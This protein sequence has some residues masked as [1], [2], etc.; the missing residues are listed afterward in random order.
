[1]DKYIAYILLV[2]ISLFVLK[3]LFKTTNVPQI[4]NNDD[5]NEHYK[6]IYDSWFSTSAKCYKVDDVCISTFP[7]MDIPEHY[8][9]IRS[10]DNYKVVPRHGGLMKILRNKGFETKEC[11]ETAPFFERS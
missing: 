7:N 10:K 3:L 8:K 2:V 9:I 6:C 1:M 11:I 5:I 4:Q